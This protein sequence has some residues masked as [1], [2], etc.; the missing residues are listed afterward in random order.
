MERVGAIDDARA[1]GGA[2]REFDRRLDALGAGIGE[3]HLVEIRHMLEQP[4]GE[5]AGQR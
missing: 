1:I 3:E 2:A 4:F 5:H